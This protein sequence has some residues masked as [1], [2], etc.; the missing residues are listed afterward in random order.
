MKPQVPN[1]V[2]RI[3]PQA[4]QFQHS[5]SIQYARGELFVMG[6]ETRPL[7]DS[8]WVGE[9]HTG[10]GAAIAFSLLPIEVEFAD[11][12]PVLL[13]PTTVA[14]TRPN[15]PYTRAA[16]NDIGQRTVFLSMPIPLA[17]E[18]AAYHDPHAQDRVEDPFAH[19]YGPCNPIAQT[20]ARQL[21]RAVF[22][23]K[24]AIEPLEFDEF[25]MQIVEHAIEVVYAHAGA[26]RARSLPIATRRTQRAWVDDAIERLCM[27]P[28][29]PWSLATLSDEVELSPGYLS[30]LFR[31]HTGH[32]LSESLM[33]VRLMHAID[34]LPDMRGQFSLLAEECGF[35]SHAHMSAAFQSTLGVA[36]K[37][38]ALQSKRALRESMNHLVRALREH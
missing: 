28:G 32:T 33:I 26:P 25:A 16:R 7:D 2:H 37:H 24:H 27:D 20:L 30:R 29:R 9:Q 5:D 6:S 36:P 13:A 35:S 1:R 3:M 18:L 31:A 17:C 21:E 15:G 12:D 8:G 19:R 10:Q 4:L 14:M 11:T 23:S 22:R 38:L 34:R